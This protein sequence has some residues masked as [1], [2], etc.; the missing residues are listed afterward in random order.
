LFFCCCVLYRRGERTGPC[1]RSDRPLLFFIGLWSIAAA[2]C[3]DNTDRAE[4]DKKKHDIG[5]DNY[6]DINDAVLQLR[7]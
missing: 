5:G 2:L 6:I 4:D 3:D 1:I 7:G